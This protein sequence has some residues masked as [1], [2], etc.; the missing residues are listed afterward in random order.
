MA[1]CP[2]C[3]IEINI[4]DEHIKEDYLRC[5]DCGQ[6]LEIASMNPVVLKKLYIEE[7]LECFEDVFIPEEAGVGDVVECVECK[8]KF[9]ILEVGNP[10]KISKLVVE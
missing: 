10:P 2:H 6:F 4:Y 1:E 7:C 5:S 9:E 8:V 3:S